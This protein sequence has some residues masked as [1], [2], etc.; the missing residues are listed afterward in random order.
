MNNRLVVQAKIYADL[1]RILSGD[2]RVL[3]LG[4]APFLEDA[5]DVRLLVL[6]GKFEMR[7][8]GPGGEPLDTG[9]D[10]KELGATLV[11]P[12]G[13]STVGKKKLETDKHLDVVFQEGPDG[14]DIETITDEEPEIRL[15]LPDGSRI[16]LTGIPEKV[17]GA[18]EENTYRYQLPEDID[19]QPGE[20]QVEFLKE[21]FADPEGGLSPMEIESF[22][23]GELRPTLSAP[24]NGGQIDVRALNES[25]TIT[26]QFLGLPEG[27]IDEE[28]IMDAAPEFL[29]GGAAAAGVVFNKPPRKIDDIT[30]EYEFSGSFGVGPVTVEFPAEGYADTDGN[31]SSAVTEGFTAVGPTASLL[32]LGRDVHELNELGYV[33]VWFEPSRESTLVVTSILD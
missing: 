23:I 15:W 28:S 4:N 26:V 19:L 32:M 18:S 17:S 1:S 14:L 25:K 2:A 22:T 24:R 21:S 9:A 10:E 3:F 29:L 11:K 30:Y 12:V 5:P 13:G 31:L 20:Y 8:F 16:V 6:K 7:F 27:A 33:D